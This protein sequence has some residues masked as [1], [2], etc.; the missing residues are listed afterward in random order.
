MTEHPTIAQDPDRSSVDDGFLFRSSRDTRM[1]SKFRLPTRLDQQGADQLAAE[2]SARRGQSVGLDAGD[3]V[4]V[5][6]LAAQLLVAACR[7]WRDDDK[8]FN[9][10]HAS[11]SF[12][13][14]IALLGIKGDE[15]GLESIEEEA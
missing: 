5:G 14:G 3:V 9:I 2:L 4:Y 11:V 12:A 13:E 1:K 15:V 6:A 10:E 7:Q 8:L